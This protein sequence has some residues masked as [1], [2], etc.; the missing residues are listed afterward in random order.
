MSLNVFWQNHDYGRTFAWL[1]SEK[2]DI[3]LLLE[4]TPDWAEAL[5][6]HSQRPAVGVE[7]DRGDGLGDLDVDLHG[8]LEGRGLKVGAETETVGGRDDCRAHA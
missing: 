3:V 7:C 8:S 6:P 4:V 2:P 1:R 5:E